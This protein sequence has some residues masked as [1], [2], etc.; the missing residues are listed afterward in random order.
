MIFYPNRES[1]DYCLA[2]TQNRLIEAGL[3]WIKA[4]IFQSRVLAERPNALSILGMKP[5]SVDG[6]TIIRLL[7]I[8]DR[9]L[10]RESL[11]TLLAAEQDFEIVAQ[12]ASSS[13]A[14]NL[15]KAAEVDVVL[16]DLA[17]AKEFVPS[18][19]KD[20]YHGKTLIIAKV[21]DATDSAAALK[22]GAAGIFFESDSSSRL[23][24]AIRMVADGEAW[25]DHRVIQILADRFPRYEVRLLGNL[26]EKERG[27]LDGVVDGLSNRKIGDQIGLSESSVKATLQQLFTKAGVRTRSQLVR[28]ALEGFY[29]ASSRLGRC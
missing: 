12:C 9:V 5:S 20:F 29:D 14:L 7:L 3:F 26:T 16:L 13:D 18:A 4:P 22:N 21:L 23:I 25:V 17:I 1:S 28:I 24:Q 2:S 27:V 6:R 10:F 8:D 11:A 19:Y 15:L